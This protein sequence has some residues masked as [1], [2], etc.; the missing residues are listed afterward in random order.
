MKTWR[1]EQNTTKQNRCNPYL[2]R[3]VFLMDMKNMDP[4]SV[5]LFKRSVA[6][7]AR[8]FS[9]SLIYAA[10]VFQ[11]FVSVVFVGKHLS[12]SLAFVTLAR[13]CATQG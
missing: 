4:Q 13:F 1:G 8:I 11:M 2:V 12:T 6:K 3:S 9:V 5:S 7:M 10:S